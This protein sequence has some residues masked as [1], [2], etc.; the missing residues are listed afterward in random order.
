M[1]RVRMNVAECDVPSASM[2]SRELIE[3]AYFRD[4][5]RVPLSRRELGI[6]DIFFAIFAHHPLW[7]QFLLI[8]RNKIASLAGLD[9]PT[10]SEILHVEIKDRYVVGEKIGLWP[11]FWLSEDELVAGRNNKHMDFR[12]SVLKVPDGDRTSVVVSTICTVHNLSGKLY[13]LFVVPF[14]RY[15]VRKLMAN[16]FATR[17]L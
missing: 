11:I 6:V 14:H 16:A 1:L 13:L 8:V 9:A 5:Y 7:M 10:A 17:R 2:L 3:R 4:S 15:G 12:L